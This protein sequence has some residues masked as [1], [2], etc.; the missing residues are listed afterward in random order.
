M[1]YTQRLLI[2]LA[3]SLTTLA[4]AVAQ[5]GGGPGSGSG[6][7]MGPGAMRMGPNN[8]G[9]WAMMSKAERTEHHKMMQSM[10]T[11]EECSAYMEKHHAQMVERAKERKLA[12]PS[13]PRRD[14]CAWLK[15]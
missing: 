6:S 10:K 12:V 9:G 15:K 2:G 8:T 5:G 13:K 14:A 11:H 7:G 3:L 4:V 1:K